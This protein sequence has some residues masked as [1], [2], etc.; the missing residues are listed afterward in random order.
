MLT[1]STI[2]SEGSGTNI[3]LREE[4]DAIEYTYQNSIN[5]GSLVDRVEKMEH[6][7]NGRIGKR[8]LTKTYYLF[9]DKGIW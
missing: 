3:S 5:A 7:V 1:P 4:M 6:S 9:E 8:F 2:L